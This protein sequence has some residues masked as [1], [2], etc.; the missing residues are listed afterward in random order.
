MIRRPPRSTLFPYTTLFRSATP[1]IV[2]DI[3][4]TPEGPTRE[5]GPL[6]PMLAVYILVGCLTPLGVFIGKWLRARGQARAQLHD[7][8]TG[9]FI[10]GVGGIGANLLLPLLTGRSPD[11]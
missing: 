6:Y 4:V 5:P 2:H 10:L 9:L 8:D 7:L 11:I 1:L 3:A